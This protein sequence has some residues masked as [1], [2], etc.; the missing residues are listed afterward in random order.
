MDASPAD[1]AAREGLALV[2]GPGASGYRGVQAQGSHSKTFKAVWKKNGTTTHLGSY[3]TP[4]DAALRVARYL[5]PASIELA[6][7][8]SAALEAAVGLCEEEVRQHAQAEGL[9][10]LPNASNASGWR[11]V[12]VLRGAN[13]PYCAAMTVDGKQKTLGSFC[14]AIEA[15]L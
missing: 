8:A 1:V 11:G 4:G 15:A 2:P 3:P 6:A 12:Q 7:A 14:T 9:V 13:R 5:G 10:L